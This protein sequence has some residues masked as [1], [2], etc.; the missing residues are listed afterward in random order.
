MLRLA[1]QYEKGRRIS[2]PT[3]RR[4]LSTT[5]TPYQVL[6]VAS[7]AS[8][9]DVKK[10]YIEKAKKCH[11]D[12]FPNDDEK[13]R[14]FQELQEAYSVLSDTK[15]RAEYTQMQR[16][17][18][19]QGPPASSKHP[20]ADYKGHYP[21]GNN[22][23]GQR[24]G[25]GGPKNDPFHDIL[26]EMLRA[27]RQQY[28]GFGSDSYKNTA[29]TRGRHWDRILLRLVIGYIVIVIFYGNLRLSQAR[30]LEADPD[31]FAHRESLVDSLLGGRRRETL[32]EA[33][34]REF[35]HRQRE[36]RELMEQYSEKEKKRGDRT[37]DEV[38]SDRP[39]SE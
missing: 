28:Q 31:K 20:Y 30:N 37:V 24:T 13:T 18:Q 21:F 22:S 12:L 26:Q 8:R 29:S 35:L 3:Y 36:V 23:Y 7:S 27:Q 38:L 33:R 2:F 1:L 15:K 4:F 11:P 17:A 39:D 6:G 32:M 9:A 5:R 10:A 16:A 25:P 14:E 19:S 34:E